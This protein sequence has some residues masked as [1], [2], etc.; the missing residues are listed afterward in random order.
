MAVNTNELESLCKTLGFSKKALYYA[1]NSKYKRYHPVSIPKANGEFRELTVPDRFM[2]SIQRS[3]VDN[4]LQKEPTS[5]Y[6]MA[7]KRGCSIKDNA[8]PHVGHK[9]LLKMDIHHFFD[10]I[11]FGQVMNKVFATSNYSRDI[12]VLLTILCTFE[13]RLPQGAPTSPYISNIIMRDFDYELGTWCDEREITYTRY[14]D[15]MTFSGEFDHREVISY[16]RRKLLKMGFYINEKKTVIVNDGQRKEV[17]GIVV[18]EKTSI[19]KDYKRNISQEMYY[20]QKFGVKDHLA[21]TGSTLSEM[22]Y[23]RNLLGRIN[24]VLSVEKDNYE[25]IQYRNWINRK[26]ISMTTAELYLKDVIKRFELFGIKSI[27]LEDSNSECLGEC[28]A[29]ECYEYPNCESIEELLDFCIENKVKT[30]YIEPV[31][32]D[33]K[34]FC[35]SIEEDYSEFYLEER[36]DRELVRLR[37]AFEKIDEDKMRRLLQSEIE[38]YI[39]SVDSKLSTLEPKDGKIIEYNFRAY[40]LNQCMKY[41]IGEATAFIDDYEPFA[42]RLFRCSQ[43]LITAMEIEAYNENV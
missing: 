11:T 15:D 43:T 7:Y 9:K 32:F 42:T 30:I 31:R 28:F 10:G 3:I 38:E 4:I 29:P 17:T 34:Y 37:R 13:E 36:F 12:Q 40:Y 20:C 27:M 19:A 2:K 5:P 25:F 41:D 18:N 35:H 23:L 21:N 24:Y 16:V 8:A 26:D 22:E 1:S 14:C 39:K 6:A 33:Y